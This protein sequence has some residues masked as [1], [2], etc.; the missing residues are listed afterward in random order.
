MAFSAVAS[1]CIQGM[2]VEL[3][4]V[5]AD[6]SNGLPVFHM[7]G[8]LSSEVKEAAQR[9]RT[10]L[11]NA[12]IRLPAK[13]IMVNLA[14]ATLRKKGASFDLA[15]AVS[16]LAA[17]GIVPEESLHGV[18]L[19]GELGLDGSVRKVPGILPI[20]RRA[21]EAGM[22]TCILPEGNGAEGALVDDI[23]IIGVSHIRQVCGYLDGSATIAPVVR[24]REEAVRLPGKEEPDFAEIC[25]Q[26][27]V[28][29]AAEVAAAGG[30]N[31]LLVGPPGSGKSMIARRIPGI[32][33][34]PCEE[35]SLEMTAVYSVLGRVEETHP[36]ITERPFREVHHTV[37]KAALI[38]GGRAPSPGEISLAHEGV[39]FLDELT[40][41]EKPVLEALR[42]P[43]EE[44]QICIARN[45]G[46]YRFPANFMLVAAMNPCPCGNYPD[47]GKCS[48]T[49]NQIRQYLG[50]ISQPFL[51]RIDLCVEA[52]RVSYEDLKGG[53]MQA[54]SSREIRKRVCAARELQARRYAGTAI[55]SNA[56]LGSREVETYCLLDQDGERFMRRAF[57]VLNLTARTYHKILKVARTI[58]DL[59]NSS[60]I[61]LPHLK[62]AAGYRT[63]DKQYW[64]R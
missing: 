19:I 44:R 57:Q 24:D 17:L 30:H 49:Q 58:A 62:E 3:I 51:D 5:E 45:H 9:V 10:A 1:A 33:P 23:C 52:P 16:V 21:R 47:L 55:R 43:L 59:E 34:P 12:N 40:E 27:G 15:V 60:Q 6:I 36:L 41:Y 56:L 32:L 14:P 37:T 35:E 11:S 31:L 53:A 54:E 64:G 28:K 7:V 48:C 25:G 38:G 13:K 29:R 39:L 46:T 8:Y 26:S 20:V 63:V 4:R 22:K 42:E 2:Q 18:L 61:L 50:K